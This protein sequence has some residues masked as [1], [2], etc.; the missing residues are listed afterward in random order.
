MKEARTC[1]GFGRKGA[2]ESGSKIEKSFK[3]KGLGKKCLEKVRLGRKGLERTG[4]G[5]NILDE[6]GREWEIWEGNVL[7]RKGLDRK[8]FMKERFGRTGFGK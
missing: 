1:K 2:Q 6:M 3:S 7:R 4:L 5:I 8:R